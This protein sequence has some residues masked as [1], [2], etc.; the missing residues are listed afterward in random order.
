MSSLPSSPSALQRAL[1]M[2][3]RRQRAA[4]Y[5]RAAEALEESARLA[6]RRADRQRAAG[7]E[8]REAQAREAA[9]Q[10]RRAARLARTHALEQRSDGPDDGADA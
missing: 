3:G 10:A 6:D 5:D 2:A 7:D 4:E 1:F 8:A 9:E